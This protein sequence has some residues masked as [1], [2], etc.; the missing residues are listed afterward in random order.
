MTLTKVIRVTARAAVSNRYRHRVAAEINLNHLRKII[1]K[2]GLD[3]VNYQ[4]NLPAIG[5]IEDF[6]R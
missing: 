3:A 5:T 2:G 1:T 4:T 6:R